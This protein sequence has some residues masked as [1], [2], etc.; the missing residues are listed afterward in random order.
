MFSSNQVLEISGEM[1]QMEAAISFALEYSGDTRC[2]TRLEQPSRCV[3]QT[4]ADGRYCI[5]WAL[6]S[7]ETPE[8][9]SEFPFDYDAAI[10]A[11][12]VRQ[13]LEKTPPPHN[14]NACWDGTS[15]LGFLLQ[16]SGG[17][18]W[19]E[20]EGIKTGNRCIVTIRPYWCYYAK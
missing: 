10:I 18:R 16:E 15:K 2:F 12:I 6:H 5:G 13:W 17:C 11:Q 20:R 8:G 7:K 19:K 4:T 1:D 3:F 14:E 9:W